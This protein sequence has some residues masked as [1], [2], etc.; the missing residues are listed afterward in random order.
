MEEIK[1]SLLGENDLVPWME[2]LNKVLGFVGD[3]V[4]AFGGLEGILLT[5]SSI[6]LKSYG[7][8]VAGFMRGVTSGVT[9]SISVISGRADQRRTKAINESNQIVRQDAANTGSGESGMIISQ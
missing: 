6:L 4:D 8:K 3:L 9:E 7:T 2:G 1:N 5:V